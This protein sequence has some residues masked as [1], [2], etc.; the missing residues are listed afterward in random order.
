M[1]VTRGADFELP[2]EGLWRLV[3]DGTSWSDWLGERADVDVEPGATG[4]VRD[5]DGV[6]REVRIERVGC[7]APV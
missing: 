3:A 1:I 6:E 2:A 5:D 4:T 7:L